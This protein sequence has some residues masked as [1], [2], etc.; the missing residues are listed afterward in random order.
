MNNH[1]DILEI[2]HTLKQHIEQRDRGTAA[3]DL[4]QMLVENGQ[5]PQELAD[6]FVSD[7]DLR[8]A[9][10]QYLDDAELEDEEENEEDADED[11]WR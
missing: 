7:R 11:D 8:A 4:V 1:D 2:W 3:E 9:V 6:S 10:N 5:D